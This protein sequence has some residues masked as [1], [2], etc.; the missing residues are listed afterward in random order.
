ME[1][2]TAAKTTCDNFSSLIADY[3]IICLLESW[4]TKSSKIDIN[5]YR[6]LVHSYRR[7]I[8]K[9]AKRASGGIIIYVRENIH[10]GVKMIKNELDCIVW[11]KLDKQ[12]FGLK[13]DIYLGI[14][15]IVP[16]NSTIHAMYD[17]DLFSTLEADIML[18]S[19]KGVVFLAGDLN[20]R[21]GVKHDYV[22]NNFGRSDDILNLFNE[23]PIAR[24]TNDK[25]IN[26]FGD[27]LLDLCKATGMCIVNGRLY[28]DVN[29]SYTCMTANGESVVDYLLTAYSNFDWLSDFNILPF[30]EYSNHA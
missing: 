19:S 4:T 3:N 6:T 24:K 1:G 8:N 26:R 30:N 11:L 21:I 9:R 14:S 20:S 22:E 15:Y 27:L 13:D 16:E 2:L 23:I 17:T 28:G 12:F 10:K 5:G 29:G 18:Y 25:G 7:F